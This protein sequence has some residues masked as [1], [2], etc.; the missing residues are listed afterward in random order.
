MTPIQGSGASQKNIAIAEVA[1][2]VPE[3]DFALDLHDATFDW[4]PEDG[5]DR[6]AKDIDEV[7]ASIDYS[8]Y[9]G[10]VPPIKLPFESHVGDSFAD[11]K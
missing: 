2:N 10:F 8:K 4:V 5:A 6:V 1:A 7:L 9:W 11:L 3:A